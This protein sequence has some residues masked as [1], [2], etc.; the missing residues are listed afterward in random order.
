MHDTIRLFKQDGMWL[1]ERVGP[2]AARIIRLFG[3]ATLVT[4]YQATT[5]AATVKAEITR[6]NPGA[7]VLV[8]S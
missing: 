4:C 6:M 1:A 8:V 3:T 7:R 5:T 2:G